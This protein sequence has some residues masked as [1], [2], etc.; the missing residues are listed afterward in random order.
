MRRP[1][2]PRLTGGTAK[3][4]RLFSVPGLDVRP[5]LA[6]LRV[7]LFEILRPRL[8]GARVADLFAGTGSLGIEALSRGA[9]H[10]I[11]LDLDPRCVEAIR[12][13]LERLRFADRGEARRADAFVEAERLG[14][15]EIVFVDPPY[16][17]Y[18][19]RPAPMR[20]LVETLLARGVTAPE[21]LVVVEH[22]SGGGLGEVA[23]GTIADER[24]YGGTSVT[25]YAPAA[26][27]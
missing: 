13:S 18:R 12:R 25:L 26:G 3:G 23:G 24:R 4:A 20:R 11:F 2:G 7:S 17:L 6:R 21:G 14:P 5:A 19:E 22:P 15:R 9:A 10:A 27:R 1:D 8:E 16:A